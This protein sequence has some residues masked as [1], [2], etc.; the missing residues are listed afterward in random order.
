MDASGW[1][2]GSAAP[3]YSSAGAEVEGACLALEHFAGP[4]VLHS[5]SD[6]VVAILDGSRLPNPTIP[7]QLRLAELA[8]GRAVTPIYTPSH[9]RAARDEMRF[10]DYVCRFAYVGAGLLN[11]SQVDSTFLPAPEQWPT[12]ALSPRTEA[13]VTLSEQFAWAVA[14]FLA[15]DGCYD[16]RLAEP[17]RPFVDWRRGAVRMALIGEIER[18][19]VHMSQLPHAVARRQFRAAQRAASLAERAQAQ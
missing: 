7:Q 12:T 1:F 5:D 15:E 16:E 3:G 19:P 14:H 2:I 13:A 17:P 6:V 9:G 10:A 18:R 4:L 8:T 11:S